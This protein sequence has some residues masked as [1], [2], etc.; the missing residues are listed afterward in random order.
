MMKSLCVDGHTKEMGEDSDGRHV[1][2][3]YFV[4][5]AGANPQTGDPI[6]DGRCAVSW[7]PLLTIENSNQQRKTA[8]SVDKVANEV[9]KTRDIPIQI[10]L[11]PPQAPRLSLNGTHPD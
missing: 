11:T 3:A 6:N 7:L 2:C 5:L 1:K 8:A 10:E 9:A 4:V